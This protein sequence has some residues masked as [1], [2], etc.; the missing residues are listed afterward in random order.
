MCIYRTAC[1]FMDGLSQSIITVAASI[2]SFIFGTHLAYLLLPKALLRALRPYEAQKREAEMDDSGSRTRI[3]PEKSREPFKPE[4]SPAL[5]VF[6]IMT[7]VLLWLAAIL[8]CVYVP[9]WRGIVMFALVFSPLGTWMRFYLSQINNHFINFPL[10]TFTANMVGTAVLAS[11]IA[12]QRT[13]RR[14][15]LQC[16]VLQGLEDG[17][18]GCLTTVSTFIIEIRKLDR[19]R[20]YIYAITSYVCGQTI[21]LLV[22]G[23]L[24]FSKGGLGPRCLLH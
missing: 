20:S 18:C 13:G 16:Q 10:G 8:V 12:L 5:H 19:R 22:L 1:Q 9:K 14:N 23:S 7:F 4:F 6:M 3:D 11:C 21:M 17:F 15:G 2:A 24:D